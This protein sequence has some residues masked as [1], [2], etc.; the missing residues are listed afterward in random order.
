[1]LISSNPK[2]EIARLPCLTLMVYRRCAIGEKAEP[3]SS[4]VLQLELGKPV[5]P[6]LGGR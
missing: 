4:S 3:N 2:R 5:F 6:P 1:M